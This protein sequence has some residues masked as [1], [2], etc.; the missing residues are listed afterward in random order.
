LSVVMLEMADMGVTARS[1]A[2]VYA[3]HEPF[4][5]RP[6]AVL[7]LRLGV[8]QLLTHR[9][10]ADRASGACRVRHVVVAG[11]PQVEATLEESRGCSSGA[12]RRSELLAL[13]AGEAAT[14]VG[15]RSASLAAPGR[16]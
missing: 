8:L 7:R 4:V 3:L 14:T 10:L 1:S 5:R 9:V 12:G 6:G 2:T 15:R 13:K 16:T 11:V